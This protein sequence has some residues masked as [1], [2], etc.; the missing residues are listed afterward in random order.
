MTIR[1]LV[2]VCFVL[3]G[4]LTTSYSLTDP[5]SALPVDTRLLG[6]WVQAVNGLERITLAASG[7]AEYHVHYRC[8][9]EG[10]ICE[11]LPTD[12]KAHGWVTE[13]AGRMWM[14]VIG[15]DCEEEDDTAC[16]TYMH[17]LIEVVDASTVHIA[18]LTESAKAIA[19]SSDGL[20][21]A[22]AGDV[23]EYLTEMDVYT[24]SD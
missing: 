5:E 13:I 4:C 16:T 10:D 9:G 8:T 1:L 23:D 12:V 17:A 2:A 15:Y 22:L 7:A 6:E 21:G 24:R 19:S 11:I 14:S 20:R 18:F 3:S